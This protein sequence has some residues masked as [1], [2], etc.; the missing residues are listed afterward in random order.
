M[1]TNAKRIKEYAKKY[2][3]RMYEVANILG[4][5]E[6]TFYST[7]MHSI[8]DAKLQKVVDAIDAYVTKA[9]VANA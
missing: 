8:D 5:G 6:S 9:G 4:V 1:I 7:Y 2:N 3:L